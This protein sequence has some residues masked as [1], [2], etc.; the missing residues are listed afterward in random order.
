MRALALLLL[1]VCWPTVV[2]G[3]ASTGPSDPTGGLADFSGVTLGAVPMPDARHTK[4][5]AL[6]DGSGSAKPDSG[7]TY[8][9]SVEKDAKYRRVHDLFVE[10][11]YLMQAARVVEDRVKVPGGLRVIVGECGE[12]NAVYVPS[13]RAVVVCHE[14]IA[15]FADH[16]QAK[17]PGDSARVGRAVVSATVFA[18]FHELG[19]AFFDVFKFPNLGSEED[20]SDRIAALLM[21]ELGVEAAQ[22]TLEGAE[23]L[24]ALAKLGDTPVWDVHGFGTQRFFNVACLVLGAAGPQARLVG[25]DAFNRDRAPR[26]GAEYGQA[27]ASFDK[28]LG[29]HDRRAGSRLERLLERR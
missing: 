15:H 7:I 25:H 14:L 23:G 18:F 4:L 6:I 8:I 11:N 5:F 2:F 28:M 12:L 24:L 9:A 17:F 27:R 19:H 16:F 13:R 3:Q 29:P 10:G 26:C 21:L 20:A 1:L 22:R